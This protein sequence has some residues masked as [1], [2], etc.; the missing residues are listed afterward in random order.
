MVYIAKIHVICVLFIFLLFLYIFLA[1][2]HT[3]F[4]HPSILPVPIGSADPQYQS[5]QEQSQP[6]LPDSD[7]SPAIIA[8]GV[9]QEHSS[10]SFSSI[11]K[12]T[13][14]IDSK[15]HLFRIPSSTQQIFNSDTSVNLPNGGQKT[16]IDG[17]NDLKWLDMD[18]IDDLELSQLL[19]SF[20]DLTNS[21]TN[22]GCSSNDQLHSDFLKDEMETLKHLMDTDGGI[23][24]NPNSEMKN[25]EMPHGV[26]SSSEMSFLDT[27]VVEESGLHPN[28]E[29]RL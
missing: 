25:S 10:T 26:G 17:M 8:Q 24:I 18:T 28:A 9:K 3:D 12:T 14:P 27:G 7:S 29:E 6:N 20:D 11:M 13:N 2:I 1:H 4:I 16:M 22:H 19:D 15:A 21:L 23:A 5:G